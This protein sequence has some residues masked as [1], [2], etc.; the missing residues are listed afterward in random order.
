[1]VNIKS[2][3]DKI[4]DKNEFILIQE[5]FK[6]NMEVLLGSM[7]ETSFELAD[8]LEE[9]DKT[10]EMYKS[11]NDDLRQ[12]LW[13]SIEMIKEKN[14]EIDKWIDEAT[15]ISNENKKLKEEIIM[16]KTKDERETKSKGNRRTG[17]H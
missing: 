9:T 3:L 14:E 6:R 12:K 1:M 5:A 11:D 15:M 8:I 13:K 10:L 16:L 4:K 17:R 7:T 2:K